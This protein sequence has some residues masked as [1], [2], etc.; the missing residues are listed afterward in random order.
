[1]LIWFGPVKMAEGMIS[2]Q[3]STTETESS[4]AA[5]DG[6]SSSRK[7][8]S[9]SFA[10]VLKSISVTS[11]RWW[12]FT[13]GR[14]RRAFA[15]SWLSLSFS[16]LSAQYSARVARTTVRPKGSTVPRPSVRPAA[17]AAEQMQRNTAPR[18]VQNSS[19]SIFASCASSAGLWQ[20]GSGG[21]HAPRSG[22]ETTTSR[23]AVP[24][25]T[26]PSW[27]CRMY[28]LPKSGLPLQVPSSSRSSPQLRRTQVSPSS[29]KPSVH[30]Q[31]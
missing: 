11:S 24:K 6:T 28:S 2:P 9:A 8:G 1:M 23:S 16:F 15:C 30:S 27:H 12:S 14:M 21:R 4:T 20:K 3:K 31:R 29:K 5:Q 25:T 18:Q 26:E 10:M 22:Q 17:R 13:S 19:F 7:M